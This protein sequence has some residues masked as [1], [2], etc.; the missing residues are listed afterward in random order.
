MKRFIVYIGILTLLF[1]FLPMFASNNIAVTRINQIHLKTLENVKM[2]T[3]IQRLNKYGINYS[4]CKNLI[5]NNQL[6]KP[7]YR[8]CIDKIS[9]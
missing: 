2:K 5:S 8:D 9:Q 4:N 6:L 1:S 7:K 3:S